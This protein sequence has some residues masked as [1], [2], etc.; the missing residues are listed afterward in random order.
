MN[1][2]AH[3]VVQV[4]VYRWAPTLQYLVLKRSE[5]DGGWWQPVTGHIEPG[6][7]ELDALKRELSEE[8]GITKLQFIS[9]P[10]RSYEYEMPDG[11]GH[12]NVYM[13]E[14][15]AKEAVRLRPE[16]HSE[17]KWT[18]LDEALGLLKYDGNKKSLQR[19]DELLA[20]AR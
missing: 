20:E 13:V 7:D 19:A 16:E 3:N 14:V 10:I 12:D 2:Y 15:G 17:Y 6:E 8:I 18:T 11:V 1:Q 5:Q 9:Q 4:I